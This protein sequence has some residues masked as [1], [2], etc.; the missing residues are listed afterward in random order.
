MQKVIKYVIIDIMRNRVMIAYTLLLLVIS[1]SAFNLADNSEK[2]LLTLL[3]IILIIVPLV[4]IVF[5]TIYIYNA[6]EF[7]E[8]LLAQPI[9]RT[10]LLASIFCGLCVSLLLSF[11][12]GAGI[13]ILVFDGSS[14]G[15]TMLLTGI[16]S[17]P[18]LFH[19][20][21][22]PRWLHGIKQRESA[23]PLC[24]GFTSPSFST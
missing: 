12:I 13:P 21:F 8:L 6:S 2:G 4:S 9:R 24:C 19:W 17:Q 10:T 15:V 7:I 23:W 22:S 5:A 18:F 3:N 16:H 1:F 14:T 20:R 11:F